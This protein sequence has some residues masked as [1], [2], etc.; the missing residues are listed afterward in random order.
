MMKFRNRGDPDIED[1]VSNIGRGENAWRDRSLDVSAVP[2]EDIQ[3]DP[4]ERNFQKSGRVRK[5][6]QG[7]KKRGGRYSPGAAFLLT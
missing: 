2:W 7:H 6:R 3:D 1:Y 5:Y 4:R